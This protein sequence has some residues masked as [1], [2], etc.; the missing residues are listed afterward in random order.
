MYMT[1]VEMPNLP[2]DTS[3]HADKGT[4]GGCVTGMYMQWPQGVSSGNLGYFGF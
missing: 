1:C 2:S 4:L 3:P